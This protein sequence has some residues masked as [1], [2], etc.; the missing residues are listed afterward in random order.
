MTKR[1]SPG[2]PARSARPVID[3]H[4]H[5]LVPEA[6]A[7][8]D[9]VARQSFADDTTGDGSIRG[10][11]MNDV[12]SRSHVHP[13][14][15]THNSTHAADASTHT[16]RRT[17]AVIDEQTT[18]EL[19]MFFNRFADDSDTGEHSGFG[20]PCSMKTGTMSTLW[21]YDDGASARQR[22]MS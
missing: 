6:N 3:A 14:D 11:V 17:P 19:R 22:D 1:L 16:F 21:P 2:R 4:G 7:L 18:P 20:G 8:A 5:L 12:I 10:A 15:L 9:F 13:P